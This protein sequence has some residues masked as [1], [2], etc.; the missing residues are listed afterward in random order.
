MCP[1]PGNDHSIHP[2]PEV[3]QAYLDYGPLMQLMKS[4]QWVLEPHVVSVKDYAAKANLF[5]TPQGYSI[6]V[7][8]GKGDFAEVSIRNLQDIKTLTSCSVYHPGKDI[9]VKI[10]L[11]VDGDAIIIKVPLHRN[12]AM[13]E[14]K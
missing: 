12:C 14:I 11:T 13:V 1:F 5:K 9:P 6:P 3:D 4:K 7:V 2:D 10:A 8:Y